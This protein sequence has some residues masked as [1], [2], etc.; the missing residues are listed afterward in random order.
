MDDRVG[1][2]PDHNYIWEGWS[3]A[4]IITKQRPGEFNEVLKKHDSSLALL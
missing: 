4:F 2:M 1:K 3:Y